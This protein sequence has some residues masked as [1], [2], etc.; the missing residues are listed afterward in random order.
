MNQRGPQPP[1]SRRDGNPPC[2]TPARTRARSPLHPHMPG[3]GRPRRHPHGRAAGSVGNRRGGARAFGPDGH[4]GAVRHLR[5]VR[6]RVRPARHRQDH[7]VPQDRRPLGPARP[8]A[9]PAPLRAADLA[10]RFRTRAGAVC[11]LS[12]IAPLPHRRRGDGGAFPAR[13]QLAPAR[14]PAVALRDLAGEP[15]PP[16][17]AGRRGGPAPRPDHRPV[18]RGGPRGRILVAGR[19]GHRRRPRHPLRLA[20]APAAPQA[21]ASRCGGEGGRPDVGTRHPAR[22]RATPPGPTRRGSSSG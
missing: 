10:G 11:R 14:A 1:W 15:S 16:G 13:R 19:T 2:H 21:L 20:L 9:A 5:P 7:D 17:D 3:A 18:Q 6:D 8:A 4:G 22:A 12:G